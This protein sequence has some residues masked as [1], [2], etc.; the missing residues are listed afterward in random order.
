MKAPRE[1]EEEAAALY[2]GPLHGFVAARN[3]RTKALRAAGLRELASAVAA[4]PKPS[5]A[6]W[7]CDQ[8]WWSEP[9]CID[10]LFA[11]AITLRGALHGAGDAEARRG[12]TQGYRDAVA[13]ATA[14]ASAILSKSGANVP[15]PT[16]RR[17]TA[18]LEAL[19]AA[20]AWPEPGPGCLAEDLDPPGFEA[21]GASPLV[22]GQPSAEHAREPAANTN[23]DAVEIARAREQL[24][25]AEATAARRDEDL[26]RARTTHVRTADEHAAQRARLDEVERR[27]AIAEAALAAAAADLNACADAAALARTAVIQAEGKLRALAGGD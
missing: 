2:R 5:A 6:A 10:E 24:A 14:R 26:E 27:L 17:I 1:L 19:A 20:G 12:P 21:L 11:A 3:A 25:L 13:R 9:A 7:A 4:L 16:Q 8:L 23:T 15:V 18:T 22:V